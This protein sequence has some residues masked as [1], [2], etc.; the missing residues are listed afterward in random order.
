MWPAALRP[1]LAPGVARFAVPPLVL[2]VPAA[3]LAPPVGAALVA[4]GAAVVWFYRDPE[5]TPP[6]EVTPDGGTTGVTGGDADGSASGETDGDGVTP[7]GTAGSP[8]GHVTPDAS[9][10]GPGVVLAPCDGRVSVVRE[11]DGRVRV[12]TF[13]SPANVHVTRAPVA[14]VVDTVEHVP[15]GHW[16][17][18]SKESERNERL[19]VRF[20]AGG[21][22]GIGGGAEAGSDVGTGSGPEPGGE[23][24][25]AVA[26]ETTMIAGALARRITSYVDGGT[27]LSAGQ[28][29][30]HIAFGSRTDVLLPP[31]FDADDLRVSTGDRV[32]AGE[33]V[34]ARLA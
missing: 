29:L 21:D 17:A 5:R 28:R 8:P 25:G 20:L 3:V 7:G 6:A 9:G 10:P 22:A 19:H 33:T 12:G 11:E 32:R 1:R 18:F 24:G 15:G 27:S 16:P 34:L 14:G 30:G 31:A 4:L 2:A 23:P 13:M 26:V